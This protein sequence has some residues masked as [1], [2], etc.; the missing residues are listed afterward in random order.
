MKRGP[1]PLLPSEKEARGTVQPVRDRNKI[2][3][4]EPASMPQMP[5]WLSAEAQ[6]IWL[7]DLGRVTATRLVTEKDTSIFAN[8][9][10]MQA[11]IVKCFK[12]NEVPPITALAE[13][14]KLQE[15]FG[16]GGARSR[17]QVKAEPG[18][19][20]NPFVRNGSRS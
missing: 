7:E 2:E 4:I 9:C 14:R 15:L 6:E 8:Y 17:V 16:I 18:A 19:G 10:A 3:I 20:G 12:A 1:K 11:S 13:V 5:D